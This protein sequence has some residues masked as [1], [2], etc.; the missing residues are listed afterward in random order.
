MEFVAS[1]GSHMRAPFFIHNYFED[2]YCIVDNIPQVTHY[3]VSDIHLPPL[4]YL[5]TLARAINDP[6]HILSLL[7]F[8]AV[9]PCPEL[10][11]CT[12]YETEGSHI[13]AIGMNLTW[14]TS[15]KDAALCDNMPWILQH[16]LILSIVPLVI[17]MR[18]VSKW[19]FGF[20]K[21]LLD[22]VLVKSACYLWSRVSLV[23]LTLVSDGV[24]DQETRKNVTVSSKILCKSMQWY[25]IKT[26]VSCSI[27]F[28]V[29]TF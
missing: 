26:F 11:P 22:M 9:W 16:S 29:S 18:V 28:L 6:L 1:N 27:W 14:T 10:A 13:C 8:D 17:F 4:T 3:L 7:I 21:V 23:N 24:H 2:Q 5:W 12:H 20:L 25:W 19:S 15:R